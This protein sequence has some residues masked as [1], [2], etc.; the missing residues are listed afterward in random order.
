M[1]PGEALHAGEHGV[2]L[3]PVD[4]VAYRMNLGGP[5]ARGL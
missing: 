3:I 4:L 1:R 5:D 2:I